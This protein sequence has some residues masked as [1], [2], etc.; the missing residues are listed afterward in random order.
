MSGFKKLAAVLLMSALQAHAASSGIVGN[1]QNVSEQNPL[2]NKVSNLIREQIS[3][4][5][6][7]PLSDFNVSIEQMN[8]LPASKAGETNVEVLSI[9][10]LGSQGSQRMDGLFVVDAVIKSN[11]GIQDK[12]I[13]GILKVV[14]PAVIARKIINSGNM[15]QD[16]DL[17]ELR[18]PWKNFPAGATFTPINQIVGRRAKVFIPAGGF[19]HS[20]IVE[21]QEA[22]RAGDWINLTLL[23]SGGVM[24]R[25]KA[26]SRQPGS[27]GDA[28]R[29]ENPDTKKILTGVIV[30]NQEVEVQ[31]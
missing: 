31:L 27:I 30:G 13:T 21:E 6:M 12:K 26:I 25:S 9:L 8:L 17:E 24:I 1:I 20:I 28:I 16:N 29:V 18:M 11:F 4:R 19:V 5:T 15:I 23:S 14:G 22:V 3:Q 7:R 2:Q 10:G